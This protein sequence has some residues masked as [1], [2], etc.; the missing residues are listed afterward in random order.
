MHAAMVEDFSCPPHYLETPRPEPKEGEV[1]AQSSGRRAEQPGTRPG[2]RIA[3]QQH[4][5][6]SLHAWTRWGW[7]HPRRRARL[8]RFS[9]RPFWIHGRIHRGSSGHDDSAACKYR[10]RGSGRAR[11]SRAR[12]M[13]ITS[14][15]GEASARRSGFGQ[16][17][18]GHRWEAGSPGGEVSGGGEGYR[19]RPGREGAC[20]SGRS[21]RGRDHLSE[22][23]ERESGT[24][25][26][27]GTA[28]VWACRWFWTICGDLPRKRSCEPPQVTGRL[29][30][31]PASGLCR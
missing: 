18:Y 24:E 17:C 8:L 4:H 26:L 13:G 6:T 11:Q 7:R 5:Q 31:S 16:R 9:T 28:R 22:P 2:E 14:R 12:D 25:I 29:K 19:D 21:G 3:L 1:P 15:Q 20:G 30:A 10:G 23:A 27:V